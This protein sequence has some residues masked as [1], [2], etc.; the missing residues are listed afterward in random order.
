MS[1]TSETSYP[2]SRIKVLLTENISKFAVEEFKHESF[3]VDCVPKG[4]SEEE[5][6][7]RVGEYHI[8][9]VRSKTKLTAKVL[10]AARVLKTIGCFCIGTDQTDLET[11]ANLGIPVF[12]APFANTRSVAELVIANLIMLARQAGDR[13]NECHRNVWNKVSKGCYEVRGK[14]LGIIGYG[15]V[16]SQVSVLAEALGMNVFFYDILKKL[17][18]GNA[19]TCR[20]MEELLA[21]SDFVSVHVPGTPETKDLIGEKEIATMPKGSYLLNLA[22]GKVVNV[23][24]TAAALHSGH[25]S[26]AAFDVYPAEPA[27]KAEKFESVLIGC[28][29]TILTPHIGGSTE[30]AQVN[31]GLE[32][33]QKLVKFMNEGNTV[34]AVNFPH[35][36]LAH[37]VS[38]HRVL[39]VHKNVPGVLRAINDVLADFNVTAQVLMTTKLIGYLMI[40]V[41]KE[42]SKEVKQQLKGLEN[43]IATR[44]LY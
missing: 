44:L 5:L 37:S 24:A 10:K 23:D 36:S 22:R 3:Q 21:V 31:I 40:E 39:N 30:E 33:A 1:E 11:A 34:D 42:V 9:G 16:G 6:L 20:T 28:P 2:K 17:P 7:E 25:L 15:H 29:N 12:N 18:L 19:T 43:S 8:I 38:T 27:S 35:V 41:D 14:K 32:V 13:N 4:L 26:G